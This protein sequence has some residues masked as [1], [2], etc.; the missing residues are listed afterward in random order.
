MIDIHPFSAADQEAY[1]MR[2]DR[3]GTD[4]IAAQQ[5]GKTLKKEEIEPLPLDGY[6]RGSR[7]STGASSLNNIASASSILNTRGLDKQNMDYRVRSYTTAADGSLFISYGSSREPKEREGVCG[8]IANVSPQGEI[9]WEAPI[10]QEGLQDVKKGPDGTVYARTRTDLVALNADGTVKFEHKFEEG[11]SRHLIDSSGNNYFVSDNTRELYEVDSEGTRVELPDA[12]KGIKG[13]ELLQ[14]SADLLYM[15]DGNTIYAVDLKDGS[16]KEECTFKDPVESKSNFSR[17]IDHFDVDSSGEVRL[18]VTNATTTQSSHYDDLHIGLGF[19]PFGRRFG[20]MPHPPMDDSFYSTQ[21]FSELSL[22]RIDK[23]GNVQWKTGTFS[24][25]PVYSQLPDGTMIYSSGAEE[26][27]PNPGYHEGLTSSP[28][29]YVPQKIGSGR[30]HIGRVSPE[31]SKDESFILVEGRPDRIMTSPSTGNLIVGHGEGVLSEFDGKGALKGTHRLP[32]V[33]EKLYP[34]SVVGD[35]TVILR[36]KDSRKLFSFDMEKGKLTSL[37]EGN[38]DHSYKVIGKEMEKDEAE[39]DVS[40]PGEVE[41]FDEWIEIDGIR[42][43]KKSLDGIQ[44]PDI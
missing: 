34:Q 6:E 30:Y 25:S 20:G 24:T 22:E 40:Q 36:D 18:W 13:H 33:G 27:I 16:R 17:Y 21:T 1:F 8:Y 19:G 41:I 28:G 29:K 4:H 23:S 12:L 38:L 10:A 26:Q 2:I 14:A 42:I 31:G 44:A 9:Q 32:D 37:T 15:R 3:V 43:Q 11:V 7:P 39:T 5:A 35:R